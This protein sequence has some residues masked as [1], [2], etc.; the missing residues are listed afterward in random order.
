VF[1]DPY[2]L[3]VITALKV[4]CSIGLREDIGRPTTAAENKLNFMEYLQTL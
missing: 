1:S 2:S 3:P 4:K